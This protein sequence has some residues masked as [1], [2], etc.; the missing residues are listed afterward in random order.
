MKNTFKSWL[1]AN[2]EAITEVI[3]VSLTVVLIVCLIP[4]LVLGVLLGVFLM[5]QLQNTKKRCTLN[6]PLTVFNYKGLR[7]LPRYQ[8]Q[9]LQQYREDIHMFLRRVL[10]REALQLFQRRKK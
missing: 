6:A 10:F 9:P 5:P 2:L 4:V 8:V 3:V 7:H 1:I